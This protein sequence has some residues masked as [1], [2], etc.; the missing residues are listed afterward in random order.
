MS[1]VSNTA[2]EVEEHA[3]KSG[4][5]HSRPSPGQNIT[6]DA[7]GNWDAK[8]G[9]WTKDGTVSQS[10]VTSL[11]YNFSQSWDRVLVVLHDV[12]GDYGGSTTLNMRL[13]GDTGSNYNWRAANTATTG[14]SKLGIA[15][16]PTSGTTGITVSGVLEITGRWTNFCQASGHAGRADSGRAFTEGNNSAIAS[17][18][19]SASLYWDNGN[20]TGTMQVFGRDI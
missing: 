12:Y 7:N 18:L 8:G 10:G 3:S 4:A 13:N 19:S 14:D 16:A 15:D 5:H 1:D 2:R 11:D 17:P 9:L 20:I 6:E